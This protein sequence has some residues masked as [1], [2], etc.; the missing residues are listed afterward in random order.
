M[1]IL[2]FL[3]D[4][5]KYTTV[6]TGWIYLSRDVIVFDCYWILYI[7]AN[8]H[9]GSNFARILQKQVANVIAENKYK[10]DV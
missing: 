9:S 5:N 10:H 3:S 1:K 4:E 6:F 7:H 8:L 2:R